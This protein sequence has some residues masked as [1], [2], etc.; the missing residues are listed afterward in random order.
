MGQKKPAAPAP[1]APYVFGFEEIC[2]AARVCRVTAITVSPTAPAHGLQYGLRVT[3]PSSG[4]EFIGQAYLLTNARE[5]APGGQG[6]LHVHP[7]TMD[8]AR[9]VGEPI[10]VEKLVGGLTNLNLG[11]MSETHLFD[12]V[13][14]HLAPS[15][16]KLIAASAG[17]LAAR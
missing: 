16:P 7:G 9:P 1:A 3:I 4:Q 2:S 13:T 12:T 11:A 5:S 15:V 6:P 17:H 14:S 10:H 8:F